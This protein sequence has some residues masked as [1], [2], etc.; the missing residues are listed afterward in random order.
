[1]RVLA[2]K[3]LTLELSEA[4]T[5]YE[6]LS[7]SIHDINRAPSNSGVPIDRLCRTVTQ[8]RLLE[9]RSR[10]RAAIPKRHRP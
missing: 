6:V 7:H 5:L 9:L 3:P 8:Q 2:V 1:M 10:V 4:L